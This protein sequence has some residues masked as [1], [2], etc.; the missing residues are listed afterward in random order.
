MKA[1]IRAVLLLS[2][3][4]FAPTPAL[5]QRHLRINQLGYAPS[6]PKVGFVLA[7]PAASGAAFRVLR[8]PQG[9][10]A[11]SGTVGVNRG[12]WGTF[13][14]VHEVDFSAVTAE[15]TFQL[16]L[17]ATGERSLTFTIDDRPEGQPRYAA[18]ARSV[19]NF[20]G[21][22]RCGN[23]S[24]AQHG[25]CHL[26]DATTVVGGPNNGSAVDVSGGWHDAGDYLKFLTT[27]AFSTHLLLWAEEVSPGLAGDL[28]V[29][30]A[31]DVL[32]ECRV[33]IDCLLRMRYAPT[34]FLYQVQDEDDHALGWR[35]AETDPLTGDRPAFFG[36]GKSHLGRYAAALARASRT[37]AAT[38]PAYSAQCLAAAV[39]AYAAIPTAPNIGGGAGGTFYIDTTFEDKI[40]LGAI[41]LYFTTGE[42]FYLTEA[43]NHA[44]LAGPG[45]WFG[46]GDVHGLAHRLIAPFHAPSLVSLE[47]DAA[48][49]LAQSNAHPWRMAGLETWGT[50]MITQGVAIEALLLEE[51]TGATAYVPMAFAQRDFLLGANAWGVCFIGGM[52]QVF[53][54]DFH[55]QIAVLQNGG[56]L[57][58]S[59]TE[60]PA[61]ADMIA[62][63][64]IVLE[65]P[66]EYLPFQDSRGTYHDDRGNW[67]TNEPTLTANATVYFLAA[68]L[69]ARL[70]AA[71][72][73]APWALDTA[74]GFRILPNPM[75]GSGEI[76]F[77]LSRAT[78]VDIRIFDVTGRRLRTLIDR[79]HLSAGSHSIPLSRGELPS[80]VYFLRLQTSEGV[81]RGAQVIIGD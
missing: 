42:A 53:P 39:D 34:K 77:D 69:Q 1:F 36:V 7:N 29:N 13:P 52:G 74:L 49:F 8:V 11:F 21:V 41:E 65:S 44:D 46:W 19:L 26:L 40:A 23:T 24:P 55:H 27:I 72:D 16:E 12:A 60:G 80:G 31:S 18:L 57:P 59:V 20:F 56:A 3:S 30:G 37:F 25:P 33:G 70:P 45:G 58:G 9:T 71:S 32:D 64:G 17:T 10:T 81:S 6:D 14:G 73:A 47:D 78:S 5:A 61:P 38:D 66:D 54:Q 22:Q 43:R 67:V 76:S 79:R 15:G 68:L 63:Q 28:N 50:T 2:F 62:E 48:N 4:A 35:P 75:R 51:L